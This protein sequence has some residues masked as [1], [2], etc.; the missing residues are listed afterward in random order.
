MRRSTAVALRIATVLVFLAVAVVA[1]RRFTGDDGRSAVT[2]PGPRSGELAVD[3]AIAAAP[4]RPVV[5]RGYVFDG[6][7]GL[8]LRLCHGRQNTS[9]PLCL[10][11]Y[12]DLDGVNEGSFGFRTG[13]AEAGV[14][15]WV[16]EPLSLRGTV[17][18]TRIAVAQ[19]LR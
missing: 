16:D 3:Q 9:P 2:V 10:G 8:G 15:K 6:P 7:G 12:L 1:V 14:V 4:L 13:R 5:V 11:P 17:N 18:G 19:V